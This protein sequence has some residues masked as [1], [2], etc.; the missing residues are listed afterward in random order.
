MYL[1]K[2]PDIVKP[3]ANNLLWSMPR[4]QK[5]VYLT[6]DDGP[7]PEVTPWVLDQLDTFDAKATFFMVG[8]NAQRNKELVNSVTSKGHS[9]GN[10]THNHINGWKT[11]TYSY[12]KNALQA[13][14]YI[15]SPLF[16]PPYGRFTRQQ[17]KALR[18][19]FTVVMWDVLSGDFDQQIDGEKCYQ[20]V[21]ENVE[22][23]S[24]IVFHDSKKAYPNL[25]YALP[26]TLAYLSEAG[27]ECAALPQLFWNPASTSLAEQLV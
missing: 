16:R 1:S 17:S 14:N 12:C 19:R 3:V 25:K 4:D 24:I 18:N 26:K 7:I 15:N 9:I 5:K 2:M 23:G 10:H 22:N 6:F 13:T 27:Y 11:P 20:N 21:V 8:D